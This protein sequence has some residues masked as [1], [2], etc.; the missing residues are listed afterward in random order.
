LDLVNFDLS[1][2]DLNEEFDAGE[3]IGIGRTSLQ[4]LLFI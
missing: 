3:I 4:I 1:D 2:D